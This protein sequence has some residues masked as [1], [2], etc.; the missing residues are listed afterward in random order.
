MG[1]DQRLSCCCANW[2]EVTSTKK[3]SEQR[4][5]HGVTVALSSCATTTH[6][7]AAAVQMDATTK[8]GITAVLRFVS[9]RTCKIYT[10]VYCG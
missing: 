7:A 3:E 8:Y 4:T 5:A 2:S 6:S 9:N 10:L 1:F